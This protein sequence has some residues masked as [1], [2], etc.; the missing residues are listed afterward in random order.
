MDLGICLYRITQAALHNVELHAGTDAAS[1]SLI[2]TGG[3]LELVIEDRG[4][5]FDPARAGVSEGIG[6]AS[7][8]ERVRLAHGEI[9]LDAAP[10]RG[11]RIVVRV[12]LQSVDTTA[13]GSTLQ[14]D[15]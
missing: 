7:M 12:P 10:G 4:K 6:L 5:G 9:E 1:V 2:N 8:E 3:T 14:D 13:A 15:V 11:T